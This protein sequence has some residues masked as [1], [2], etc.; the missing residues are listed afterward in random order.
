ME[1]RPRG[2]PRKG[3]GKIEPWQFVRAAL[4][5]C[6]Y[7][8][9]RKRG[10]KHR[11]AVAQAVAYVK[12]WDS[13]IRISETE[14]RRILASFRPKND[15]FSFRFERSVASKNQLRKHRSIR[16]QLAELQGKKGVTLPELPE[17]RKGALSLK[18]RLVRRPLYPRHNRRTSKK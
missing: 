18:I 2:R 10:E 8:E 15:Q 3:I 9:A 7:D 5:M 17:L 13:A 14:V 6:G 12:Q 16:K 4:V 11:D 1:V